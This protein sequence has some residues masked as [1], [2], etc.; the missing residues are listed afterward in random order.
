[1][2]TR[3]PFAQPPRPPKERSKATP[4]PEKH[5][6][7]AS[8]AGNEGVV[9]CPKDAPVRSEEYRRLVAAYPC[10]ACF[11]PNYSQCAHSNSSEDGKGLG[12]KSGD[13]ATA[14]LCCDRPG[15]VGCHTL[16]DRGLLLTK[17]TRP[18]VF[19][20]W[21]ADTQRKIYA[22]GQWPAGLALPEFLEK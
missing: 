5:R 17:A 6:R 22:S 9:V 11:V 21:V 12:I 19:A 16:W 2:L 7:K 13:L 14:P 1:M 3:K 18:I 15:I 10:S 8:Y 20:G 4:V